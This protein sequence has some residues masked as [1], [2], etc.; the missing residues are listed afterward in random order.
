MTGIEE[1]FGDQGSGAMFGHRG[2][3]Q[4]NATR[5]IM[6]QKLFLHLY[7]TFFSPDEDLVDT[8]K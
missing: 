4:T 8:L 3:P 5:R 7:K 2:G 6:S 1:L